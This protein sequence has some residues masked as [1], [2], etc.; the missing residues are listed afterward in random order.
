M[1]LKQFCVVRG[2]KESVAM[3]LLERQSKTREV[4]S[5]SEQTDPD[6]KAVSSAEET[7]SRLYTDVPVGGLS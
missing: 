5:K 6:A 7:I 2:T 3:A 4:G 1:R